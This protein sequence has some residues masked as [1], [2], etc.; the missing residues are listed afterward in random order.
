QRRD[1]FS[2]SRLADDAERRAAV[3]AEVERVH[4]MG[5]AAAVAMKGDREAGYV[6]QRRLAHERDCADGCASA[7]VMPASITPRSVCPTRSR[8][9]GRNFT[10]CTNRSR[11]TA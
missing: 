4:G 9:L 2:A 7:L 10:K 8:R 3:D 11:L 1:A 6:E 5:L